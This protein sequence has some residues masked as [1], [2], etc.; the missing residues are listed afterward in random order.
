MPDKPPVNAAITKE[1]AAA[2][3]RLPRENARPSGSRPIAR[4]P[5]MRPHCYGRLNLTKGAATAYL[6]S[7]SYL[8][9][10]GVSQG[11]AA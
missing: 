7:F 11:A 2:K 3:S 10:P 9:A 8:S 1:A 6:P 5:L 4:H